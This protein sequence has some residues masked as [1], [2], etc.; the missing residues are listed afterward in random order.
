[1]P[2]RKYISSLGLLAGRH[3]W[4][5]NSTKCQAGDISWTA[6]RREWGRR[7]EMRRRWLLLGAV[8]AS[9]FA[10]VYALWMATG[11]A[12]VVAAL[13]TLVVGL[14]WRDIGAGRRARDREYVADHAYYGAAIGA[15]YVADSYTSPADCSGGAG[16]FGGDC[17]AGGV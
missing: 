14:A 1:M 4:K 8:F 17:G 2:R 7:H 5:M 10:A 16:G 6:V 12:L 13:V 3:C 11:A 9:T 15:A